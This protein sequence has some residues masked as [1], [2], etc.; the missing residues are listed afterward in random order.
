MATDSLLVS[1]VEFDKKLEAMC[2]SGY[3]GHLR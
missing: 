2:D 3:V 1:K